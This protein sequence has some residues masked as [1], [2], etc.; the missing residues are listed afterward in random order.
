[1][2]NE[3][4]DYLHHEPSL[5]LQQHTL[6]PCCYKDWTRPPPA[7]ATEGLIQG[8]GGL[9]HEIKEGVSDILYDPVHGIYQQGLSGAAAGL[10]SGLNSLLSRPMAGGS[11]LLN[12]VKTGI[13]ASLAAN[14]HYGVEPS[15]FDPLNA[16]SSYAIIGSKHTNPS[17]KSHHV[18][19]AAPLGLNALQATSIRALKMSLPDMPPV[20]SPQLP[21]KTLV[22]LES[23]VA[24][25]EVITSSHTVVPTLDA[26]PVRAKQSEQ[27][28]KTSPAPTSPRG[29][30]TVLDSALPSPQASVLRSASLDSSTFYG[31]PR[32]PDDDAVVSDGDDSVYDAEADE[33]MPFL[34]DEP[35]STK[36]TTDR[37]GEEAH[38]MQE[39]D[40]CDM[41]CPSQ[42][43]DSHPRSSRSSRSS[44]SPVNDSVSSTVNHSNDDSIHAISPLSGET[45]PAPSSPGPLAP[46]PR[47][48]PDALPTV[49]AGA[50][51][52]THTKEQ[53]EGAEKKELTVL[54]AFRVAQDT[55]QLFTALGAE[56]GR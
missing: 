52:S 6:L 14:L 45:P 44:R 38:R 9:V 10:S 25:V 18:N 2:C 49:A 17:A 32:D 54:E 21:R 53:E 50:S 28:K 31:A 40:P 15:A 35:T 29:A 43:L 55:Q 23:D 47:A 19:D 30:T 26:S 22:T 20:Y 56:N 7:S 42:P 4:A 11:V 27:D 12:K 8:L 46:S 34:L 24:E 51:L 5:H 1:M 37:D 41:P 16:D 39:L 48:V 36:S 13:Q 33:A 3:V